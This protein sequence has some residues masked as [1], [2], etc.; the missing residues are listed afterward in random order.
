[1][2]EDADPYLYFKV[3]FPLPDAMG[4]TFAV[5]TRGI[6]QAVC[7]EGQVFPA[8]IDHGT[9]D[10][11]SWVFLPTLLM[12]PSDGLFEARFHLTKTHFRMVLRAVRTKSAS[13][14][15]HYRQFY[16]WLA[17]LLAFDYKVASISAVAGLAC[18]TT[19]VSILTTAFLALESL[20]FFA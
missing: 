5:P 15:R 10:L 7:R 8:T 9:N 1:M 3:P 19:M 12:G 20:Y 11:S 14:H 2:F 13:P 18:L 6:L 17:Q 4:R 16:V